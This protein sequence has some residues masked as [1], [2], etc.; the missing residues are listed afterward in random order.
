MKQYQRP[1]V[2]AT[3]RTDDLRGEAAV[4]CTN[5]YTYTYPRG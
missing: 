4:V 5:S 3:Y 2:I 1:V